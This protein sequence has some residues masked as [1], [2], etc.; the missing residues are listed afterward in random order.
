MWSSFSV[1]LSLLLFVLPT[2][3]YLVS[4]ESQLHLLS[5][6]DLLISAC[7]FPPCSVARNVAQ[8]SKL[9]QSQGSLHLFCVCNYQCL[10]CVCLANHCFICLVFLVC[11]VGKWTILLYLERKQKS[12]SICPTFEILNTNILLPL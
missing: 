6:K 9:G 2:L 3:V 4:T 1:Q 7:I 5:S 8:V 12:Y 10:M 11:Q